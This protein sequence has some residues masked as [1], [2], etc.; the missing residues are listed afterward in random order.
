VCSLY[1]ASVAA[2]FA[3]T[4]GSS[5]TGRG[6][7]NAVM[8]SGLSLMTVRR[9]SGVRAQAMVASIGVLATPAELRTPK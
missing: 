2:V 5:R 6:R 9:P 8:A 4:P 3:P 7:R 1:S